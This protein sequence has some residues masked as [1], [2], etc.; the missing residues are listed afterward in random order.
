MILAAA[1]D[2]SPLWAVT[3]LIALG[4]LWINLLF[5]MSIHRPLDR[6]FTALRRSLLPFRCGLGF[7]AN[8]DFPIG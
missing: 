4:G 7:T 3:P 2:T 6:G 1:T 8:V 5:S